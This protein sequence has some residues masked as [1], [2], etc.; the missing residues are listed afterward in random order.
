M[1]LRVQIDEGANGGG[2]KA[3]VRGQSTHS[4]RS[5]EQ[6]IVQTMPS[7][8]HRKFW[9]I[10]KVCLAF[11]FWQV[12]VEGLRITIPPLGWKFYRGFYPLYYLPM[13][14]QLNM[15]VIVGFGMMVMVMWSWNKILRQVL[16]IEPVHNSGK[17]FQ[18]RDKLLIAILGTLLLLCDCGLFYVGIC[19]LA[20][21]GPKLSMTAILATVSYVCIIVGVSYASID[22]KRARK[23]VQHLTRVAVCLAACMVVGGCE[24]PEHEVLG[25]RQSEY[26]LTV[27]LDLSPSFAAHLTDGGAWKFM[28]SILDRYFQHRAG[29]SDDIIVIAKISGD[30]QARIWRGTPQDLREQFS[31]PEKF[32][33][34]L[35]KNVDS[36]GSR[37][38]EA[39]VDCLRHMMADRNVASGEAKSA[40]FVLSDMIESS[41]GAKASEKDVVRLLSEYGAKHGVV[42]LYFVDDRLVFP[43]TDRLRQSGVRFKISSGIERNPPLPSFE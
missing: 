34:F 31:S 36:S 15:A 39:I 10:L 7:A 42:G 16:G 1:A 21:G 40:L 3:E 33:E 25:E 22:A 28:E 8:T 23:T 19:G 24:A 27:L 43:W 5:A 18:D 11:V 9:L 35:L 26:V 38:H 37:V 32:R 13:G 30:R 2:D 14:R 4:V 12:L 20:W 29:S 6:V 41:A 17:W